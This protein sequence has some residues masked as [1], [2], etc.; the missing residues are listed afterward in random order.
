VNASPGA[1]P[2]K[3]A[4]HAEQAPPGSPPTVE[5]SLV[6]HAAVTIHAT[7]GATTIENPAST[8]VIGVSIYVDGPVAARNGIL[9]NSIGP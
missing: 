7:S 4:R 5:T 1:R 3:P 8:T 9:T 6:T 2:G